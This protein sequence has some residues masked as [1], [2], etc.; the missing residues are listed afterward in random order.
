[1]NKLSELYLYK[2]ELIGLIPS[3]LGHLTNLLYLDLNSNKINGSI[4]L[5]I[6][7]MKNLDQLYLNDNDIFGPIPLT[8]GNLTNLQT[9]SLDRNKINVSIPGEIANC[10]LLKTVTFSH[11]NL[12]GFIPQSIGH[13]YSLESLSLSWNQIS[14]SILEEIIGCSIL[15]Y[16]SLSHNY[17]NG[18]VPSKIGYLNLLNTIDLSH[19]NIT[20]EIPI[21][22]GSSM[23]LEL[24]DLSYNNFIGNIPN[25]SI[26]IIKMNFSYNSLHGMIPTGYLNF[27]PYT[28]IGNKDLYGYMEGFPHCPPSSPQGPH[29]NRSIVHQIKFLVL[30]FLPVL[31]LLGCVFLFRSR[32]KKTKSNPM[33]TKNGDLFSIWNYGGKIAYE[34][35]IEATKDFDIRYCIGTSGYGSVYKTQLSNGNVVALKK[36]NRLE[37]KDPTFDKSFKNEIKMLTE[38]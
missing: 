26:S 31:V 8:I 33:G 11:N 16:L 23:Y 14:G 29:N 27:S 7:H 13:L 3:S 9:F 25:F 38:I 6:D 5:E 22:L 35:I 10:F 34:D 36:L 20:G 37:A 12:N 28:F 17:F 32:I 2:N 21:E 24:L 19:N 15:K 30:G 18:S 1:M 4:P